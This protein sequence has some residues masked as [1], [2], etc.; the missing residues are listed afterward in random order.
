MSLKQLLEIEDVF[1]HIMSFLPKVELFNNFQFV[2]N[3]FNDKIQ[4]LCHQI[5][6]TYFLNYS[7]PQFYT[8]I[9][10]KKFLNYNNTE[11]NN[12][13]LL[14][15]NNKDSNVT[16]FEQLWNAALK[17]NIW[18]NNLINNLI[19]NDNAI[20]INSQFNILNIKKDINY[21][22]QFFYSLSYLYLQNKKRPD[23][24]SIENLENLKIKNKYFYIFEI[25]IANRCVVMTDE[26]FLFKLIERFLTI[27]FSL[28][29]FVK[30]KENDWLKEKF[31]NE[32]INNLNIEMKKYLFLNELTFILF[33]LESWIKN[34]GFVHN[35]RL[36]IILEDFIF[37]IVNILEN[38]NFENCKELILKCKS[39]LQLLFKTFSNFNFEAFYKLDS[40]LFIVNENLLQ[41]RQEIF[42]NNLFIQSIKNNKTTNLLKD[43]FNLDEFAFNFLLFTN[44][45]YKNFTTNEIY[46][47]LQLKEKLENDY[48]IIISS[49][50]LYIKF[51]KNLVNFFTIEFFHLSDSNTRS[52]FLLKIVQLTSLFYYLKEYNVVGNFLNILQTPPLFRLKLTFENTYKLMS[53]KFIELF[54]EVKNTFSSNYGYRKL[55]NLD[56]KNTPHLGLLFTDIV[57]IK[58]GNSDISI[59]KYELMMI[60]LK[61]LFSNQTSKPTICQQD[62]KFIQNSIPPN[63]LNIIYNKGFFD[64]FKKSKKVFVNEKYLELFAYLATEYVPKP[65]DDLFELS[66]LIEPR[67]IRK[68]RKSN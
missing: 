33:I 2:N 18:N 21:Y 28:K 52:Q 68:T 38:N 26:M 5:F 20:E 62:T 27:L 64:K 48:K 49:L 41:Q 25:M 23:I 24:I 63:I 58:D 47:Q 32:Q 8:N 16:S 43:D 50:K 31:Y 65:E 11:E 59:S 4:L 42:N 66:L 54:Q 22:F 37:Y 13:D 9:V 67:K 6:S 10:Y 12:K 29:G 56:D 53:K 3:Y 40:L 15:E 1:I 30:F 17:E 44:Y 55:R 61:K 39:I 46:N 45:L 36:N 14:K 60:P 57:F 34:Y 51:F 7:M 35:N 19:N